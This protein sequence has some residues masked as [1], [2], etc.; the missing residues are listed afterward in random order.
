MKEYLPKS[1]HLSGLLG[2]CYAEG[3]F[4]IHDFAYVSLEQIFKSKKYDE[5]EF[6]FGPKRIMITIP[7]DIQLEIECLSKPKDLHEP[8]YVYDFLACKINSKP[9]RFVKNLSI[10]DFF[11]VEAKSGNSPISSNQIRGKSQ[12]Q[13]K[14]MLCRTSGVY[15]N[16]PQNVAID[17]SE[18]LD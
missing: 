16:I 13:I 6:K 15:V 14:I 4:H 18:L 3:Y 2:E 10:D 9:Q 7:D 1:D 17:F 12:T 11:W 8:Y 5:I